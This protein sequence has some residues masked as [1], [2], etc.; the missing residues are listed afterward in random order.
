MN[1]LHGAH[2]ART[3]TPPFARS[4]TLTWRIRPP[5]RGAPD[6]FG[7]A[8]ESVFTPVLSLTLR[9]AVA[10][11]ATRTF[12]Q[13]TRAGRSCTTASARVGLFGCSLHFLKAIPCP[14]QVSVGVCQPLVFRYKPRDGA[15]VAVP[16]LSMLMLAGWTAVLEALAPAPVLGYAVAPAAPKP[17]KVSRFDGAFEGLCVNAVKVQPRR[18]A[19]RASSLTFRVPLAPFQ[20][21][22]YADGMVTIGENGMMLLLHTHCTFS[23]PCHGRL[24]G[25]PLGSE[26]CEN[27]REMP[28]GYL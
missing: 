11:H 10:N 9:A 6:R 4:V 14:L 12:L 1:K 24:Y 18:F 26:T 19:K 28:G 3:P 8:C 16:R 23:G 2:G 13:P 21:A 20:A 15:A 25:R 22:V 17:F 7:T 27:E 5:S